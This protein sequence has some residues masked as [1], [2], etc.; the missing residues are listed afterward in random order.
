MMVGQTCQYEKP[1]L[2]PIQTTRKPTNVWVAYVTYN[3]CKKENE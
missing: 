3:G 1:T 2:Y